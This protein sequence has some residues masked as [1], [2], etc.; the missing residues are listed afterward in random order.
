MVK[1]NSENVYTLKRFIQEYGT[2]DLRV[3]AFHLKEV[4]FDN[5]MDHKVV[6]NGDITSDKYASEL[7]ANKKWVSLSTKE[8][9]HYRFN[10]KL[11]SYDVYGTTEL[12]FFILMANE[13]YTM[14]EFDLRRLILYDASVITK[15]N[16]MLNL[17]KNRIEVN[18]MEVKRQLES[19]T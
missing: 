17:E 10:P 16:H 9:Y 2:E 8:Y 11:L 19:S 14:A 15:L 13:L 12:W 5:G 6:V 18:G 1:G 4:L 7:E 3:D